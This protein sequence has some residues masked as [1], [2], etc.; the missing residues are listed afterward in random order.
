MKKKRR[1]L[2]APALDG[3]RSKRWRLWLI[4]AVVAA[5]GLMLWLRMKP[6]PELNDRPYGDLDA[7]L[8]PYR[9]SGWTLHTPPPHPGPYRNG[10]AGASVGAGDST[11]CRVRDG[12]KVVEE[13]RVEGNPAFDQLVVNLETPGGRETMAVLKRPR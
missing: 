4:V 2:P 1:M 12:E 13:L 9:A 10:R 6:G 3:G 7:A 11:I 5:A 8:A